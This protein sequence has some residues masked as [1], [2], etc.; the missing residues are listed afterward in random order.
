MVNTEFIFRK[1]VYF[2]SFILFI[3]LNVSFYYLTKYYSLHKAEEKIEDF[4]L[5][6]KA[7][8]NFVSNGQKNE[9]YSMQKEDIL[10]K[11][12]FSPVLMSSTY[13]AT[14]VNEEYNTLLASI[15]RPPI[16]IRFSSTNPRNPNNLSNEFETEL[17]NK[18]NNKELSVYKK[19]IKTEYGDA[20][21]Y[22]LPTKITTDACMRC[23]SD[24]K[25]APV[26]LVKMYGDKAGFYE[27]KGDVRAML[28]TLYPMELEYNDARNL[29][30]I[31]LLF[32]SIIFLSIFL[33]FYKYN[34]ILHKNNSLL[35]QRV[36]L[37]ITNNKEKDLIMF[38]QSKMAAMGEMIENITHQWKQP[39]SAMLTQ[40]TGTLLQKELGSINEEA[41]IHTLETVIKN[42]NYLSSTIDFF[43]DF[44]HEDKIKKNINISKVF[45]RTINIIDTS[46][47]R[48]KIH[49]ENSIDE[50][51]DLQS[52]EHE[53]IQVFLNIINNSKDALVKNNIDVPRYILIDTINS[54]K[55]LIISIVDNAGGID[56][57]ILNKVF[58]QYFTTKDKDEGTGIGLY[59]SKIIVEKHL[60]GTLKVENIKFNYNNVEY[61][62]AKFS[63][64][65]YK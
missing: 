30:L 63:I 24:P 43:R 17:L 65:L 64:K 48:H 49:I 18:F 36:E 26:G 45:Q 53:L 39:L 5:N 9:I 42:T 2:F 55:E 14:R 32:T 58:E 47:K 62:G 46:I 51:I 25:I 13:I 54:D 8:R 57:S 7:L 15:N 44:F 59:M 22:A 29:F 35:K 16:K 50:T 37:E 1:R 10:N 3:L 12:F 31:L 20:L 61:F 4:L 33:F 11:D 52:Y 6:V 21:Y 56:E 34:K 28:S 40:S 60:N 23:H 19:V 41:Y 27:H 38:Q